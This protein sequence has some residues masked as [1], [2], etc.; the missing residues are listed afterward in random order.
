MLLIYIWNFSQKARTEVP[1]DKEQIIAMGRTYVDGS[2]AGILFF[3]NALLSANRKQG[4]DARLIDALEAQIR[5]TSRFAKLAG[6]DQQTISDCTSQG[7]RAIDDAP[8]DTT[9]GNC[10]KCWPHK[11]LCNETETDTGN[12]QADRIINR[13]ESS[14]PDFDD[15]VNAVAFIRR[16]VAEHKGPDGFATWKDAAIHERQLRGADARPVA[17]CGWTGNYVVDNALILLDRLDVSCDDDLRVD[18]IAQALRSLAT[19]DATPTIDARPIP[20]GW[21]MRIEEGAA[22]VQKEGLGGVVAYADDASIAATILHALVTDLLATRDAAPKVDDVRPVASDE[23]LRSL[24]LQIVDLK[25]GKLFDENIVSAMNILRNA[26]ATRDA[27]PSDAHSDADLI[28]SL[29]R[30][31]E[32]LLGELEAAQGAAPRDAQDVIDAQRYRHLRANATNRFGRQ[33]NDEE[34]DIA[35]DKAIAAGT[36]REKT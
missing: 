9:D 31:I 10:G 32:L 25:K 20:E 34:F 19:R 23:T 28:P 5:V 6:F 8:R 13:L 33:P 26:I 1:V 14:D 11:C 24:V 12:A 4:A 36:P 15:C 29:H 7:R 18:Q 27:A 3:A 30:T 35:I 16:L 17:T 22:V 2:D 21:R